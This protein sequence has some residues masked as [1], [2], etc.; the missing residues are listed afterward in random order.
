MSPL[1]PP[2]KYPKEALPVAPALFLFEVE[3][4]VTTVAVAVSFE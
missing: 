3:N 4:V 1:A 2:A